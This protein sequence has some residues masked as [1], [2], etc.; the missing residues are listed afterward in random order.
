MLPIVCDRCWQMDRCHSL[1]YFVFLI[2]FNQQPLQIWRTT[3]K[4]VCHLMCQAHTF[5]IRLRWVFVICM[6]IILYNPSHGFIVTSLHSLFIRLILMKRKILNISF[7][8]MDQ[9]TRWGIY[10][11]FPE[12]SLYNLQFPISSFLMLNYPLGFNFIFAWILC[13]D[14]HFVVLVNCYAFLTLMNTHSS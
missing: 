11:C 4:K 5:P 2:F 9:S 6:K 8:L 13:K 3:L 14:S 12:L 7:G 10:W 1:D